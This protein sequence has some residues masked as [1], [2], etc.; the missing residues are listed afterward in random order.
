MASISTK[1]Y[2]IRAIHEWCVDNGFTPHLSVVVDQ[3]T[4][5]PME[6]V[7]DGQIVLNLA[8]SATRNLTMDND[9]VQFS[10]RFGGVSRELHI[11]MSAVIGIFARENGEGMGFAVEKQIDTTTPPDPEPPKPTK[12]SL[13]IVK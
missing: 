7:K 11:P 4:R 10:A 8:A 5:V 3:N 12:P 6:F 2:L 1:P 9:W 13:K